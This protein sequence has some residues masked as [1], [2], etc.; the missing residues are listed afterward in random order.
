M[1]SIGKTK[2]NKGMVYYVQLSPGEHPHRP[3]IRLGKCTK[4]DAINARMHIENLVQCRKTGSAMPLSTTE[5]IAGLPD[6]LRNRLSTL[7]IAES[8]KNK[9]WTVAAWVKDYIARRPD[10][11]EGTRRKWR[12]VEEKLNKFFRGDFIDDIT[13]HNAK[14][15]RLY[16]QTTVGLSE[17]T[18][19]RHIGITR[20]FFNSAIEAELLTKNPFRGQP[21]SVRANESRFFYVTEEIAQRVLEAC[22]D[23]EWRLIFGLARWGGL[24][25]PSEVVRLKWI[26]VDF[27]HS[28][29]KVHSPKTEHHADNGVRIVPMFPQLRPLFQDAFDQAPEGSSYCVHSCLGQWSNLGALLCKIIKKAGIEPWPKLMQNLRSTRETEL[30]KE[31]NGNIKAVCSWLGNS[32]AIALQHYAQT[33]EADLKEAAKKKILNQAEDALQKALQTGAESGCTELHEQPSDLDVTLCGCETKRQDATGC[34][35]IQ[36]DGNW[37]LLDLNQ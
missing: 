29:F 10:V 31:T 26:D 9:Q 35:S 4:N 11:K 28:K 24:R 23:A 15:F 14:N 27:E 33:T 25:C 36:K 37:A 32:P 18:I 1:A 5:W 8:N 34:N 20:Q 16:L 12:D 13:V 19:R 2:G 7:G 17:N 30:F 6:V 21:V 22:P 3:L